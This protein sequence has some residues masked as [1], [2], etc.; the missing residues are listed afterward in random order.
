MAGGRWG[1]KTGKPVED[2]PKDQPFEEP[3]DEIVIDSGD[4]QDAA[5]K[6]LSNQ[7]EISEKS[8]KEKRQEMIERQN[9]DLQKHP[10]FSKF[11]K[12]EK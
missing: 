9:Q 2:I 4:N 1:K 12:G 3:S 8:L 11:N 7:K 6:V 10:K 5:K